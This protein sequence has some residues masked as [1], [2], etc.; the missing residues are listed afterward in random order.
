M[1]ESN[2]IDRETA[3]A[4]FNRFVDLMDLDLDE[5][6]MDSEDKKDFQV[7]REK[8]IGCIEKGSLAISEKGEPMFTPQRSKDTST[9][10]F[11]EPTGASLMAMDRKQKNAD[12]SKMYSVMADMTGQTV[13]RFSA[14]KYSDLKVCQSVTTLFLA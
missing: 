4:E 13:T 3:V 9:L 11:Q 10:T 8:L 7:E 1:T 2:L 12:V 14:M 6:R 5:S